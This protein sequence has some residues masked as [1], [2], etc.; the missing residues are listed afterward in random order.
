MFSGDF[1]TFTARDFVSAAWNLR[2]T[3][4]ELLHQVSRAGLGELVGSGSRFLLE[5]FFF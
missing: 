4:G 5:E 2:L 1:S 3:A